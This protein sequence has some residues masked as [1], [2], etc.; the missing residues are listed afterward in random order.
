M[1]QSSTLSKSHSRQQSDSLSK[2]QK[3]KISSKTR[4]QLQL[5]YD[6]SGSQYVGQVLDIEAGDTT[7]DDIN[8][9]AFINLQGTGVPPQDLS[10]SF[11]PYALNKSDNKSLR[12]GADELQ[13]I[14]QQSMVLDQTKANADERPVTSKNLQS[15]GDG[16]RIVRLYQDR[17]QDIDELKL[18]ESESDDEERH[19]KKVVQQQKDMDDDEKVLGSD[20][21]KIQIYKNKKVFNW[22]IEN[23]NFLKVKSLLALKIFA[24]VS[25]IIFVSLLLTNHFIMDNELNSSEKNF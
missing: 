7:T 16:I 13:N 4:R 25:I 24:L 14:S 19:D 12:L 6:V 21:Q 11:A 8:N 2:P 10:C 23:S 5:L 17:L 1:T 20:S 3:G 9:T 22:F 18:N 15:Y